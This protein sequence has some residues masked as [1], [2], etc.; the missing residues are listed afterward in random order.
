M[1]FTEPN[2]SLPDQVAAAHEFVAKHYQA[3]DAV[4]GVT[5]S[6]PARV[7]QG[8]I[9]LSSLTWLEIATVVAVFVIVAFAFRSLAAPILALAVA[10]VAIMLTLH[11]GGWLARHYGIAVPQE[12][13]PL[14]VA[15]LLGVVTDYVVFY[16][17]A[18]RSQLAK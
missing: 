18:A 3:D 17:S 1:L 11:I 10:G 14:I 4:V 5:G 15:L 12:A 16:L 13:Q 2:V 9:V 6:V 7:E 8:Q